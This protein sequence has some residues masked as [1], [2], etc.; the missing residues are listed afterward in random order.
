MSPLQARAVTAYARFVSGVFIVLGIV[1]LL[2][3]EFDGFAASEGA[4]LLHMTVNPLMSLVHLAAGLGGVWL[5]RNLA[6]ARR[7]CLWTGVAASLL[8]LLEFVVG[9][10]DADILGRDGTLGAVHVAL[11]LVGL[12]IGLWSRPP[13][14]DATAATAPPA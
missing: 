13:A 1:G 8:G 11:G 2:K 7:F 14:T 4:S 5:A 6:G 12:A 3:T 10:S 9:D